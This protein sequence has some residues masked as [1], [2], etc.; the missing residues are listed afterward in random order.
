MLPDKR[1]D[2]DGVIEKHWM[3]SNKKPEQLLVQ[4][5]K[6]ASSVLINLFM[7]DTVLSNEDSGNTHVNFDLNMT[8]VGLTLPRSVNP[9]KFNSAEW[10]G[11]AHN[12]VGLISVRWWKH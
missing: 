2:T 4:H 6:M 3:L 11:Q 5:S 10:R 9:I 12:P 8:R 7:E 1:Q